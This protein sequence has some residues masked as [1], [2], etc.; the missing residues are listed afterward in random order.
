MAFRLY[1]RCFESSFLL[2]SP[3]NSEPGFPIGACELWQRPR[4]IAKLTRIATV[5]T[6]LGI[7]DS[8]FRFWPPRRLGFAFFTCFM[9]LPC[10]FACLPVLIP[11]K[12]HSGNFAKDSDPSFPPW[13]SACIVFACLA[14]LHAL[15]PA[16][17]LHALLLTCLY[18]FTC[19]LVITLFSRIMHA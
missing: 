7:L 4:T 9:P 3:A 6:P 13:L 16:L 1:F 2:G 17:P 12:S 8:G 10:L 5:A 18:L 19:W 14:C 15:L 11:R